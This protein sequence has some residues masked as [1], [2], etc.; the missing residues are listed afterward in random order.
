MNVKEAERIPSRL[1]RIISVDLPRSSERIRMTGQGGVFVPIVVPSRLGEP[2]LPA[3][4]EVV[5][6]IRTRHAL[7]NL[8]GKRPAASR[9][10]VAAYTN[11]S[12]AAYLGRVALAFP[13]QIR[14]G[15]HRSAYAVAIGSGIVEVT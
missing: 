5:A 14:N 4:E 1:I 6:R 10:L 11:W 2:I 7:D 13:E 15:A 12:R 8:P 3:R 9:K